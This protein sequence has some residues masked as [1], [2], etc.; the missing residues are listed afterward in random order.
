MTEI[1]MNPPVNRW[2]GDMPKIGIR[3][4]I[5]GRLGGV[6]ESLEAQTMAMAKSVAT[7]LSE[8]LRHANGLPVECVIADSTIGRVA[9]SARCREAT[10][11]PHR[12]QTFGREQTL[13][14]QVGSGEM[15]HSRAR[16]LSTHHVH[17]AQWARARLTGLAG[18][19]HRR[20]TRLGRQE[21]EEVGGPRRRGYCRHPGPRPRH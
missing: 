19:H 15:E 4:A 16:R 20:G 7:L 6:R 21:A 2:A 10:A 17:L 9:E 13:L 3:P 18:K 1:K 5:D 11:H 12:G 8:N 14:P